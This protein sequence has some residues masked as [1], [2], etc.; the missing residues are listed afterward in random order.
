[1]RNLFLMDNNAFKKTFKVTGF[2]LM[3]DIKSDG[4]FFK[5]LYFIVSDTNNTITK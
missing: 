1:M 4:V 5:D 2:S 3:S